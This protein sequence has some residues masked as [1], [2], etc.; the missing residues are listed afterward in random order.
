[1]T[2]LDNDTQYDHLEAF[3]ATHTPM[4]FSVYPMPTDASLWCVMLSDGT[5]VYS[6]WGEG[7]IL[8]IDNMLA[9]IE[10]IEATR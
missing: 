9:T 4:V 2:T 6:G 5:D 7:V 3:F 10:Q 1:M 8:A